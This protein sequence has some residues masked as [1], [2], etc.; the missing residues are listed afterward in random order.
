LPCAAQMEL[1]ALSWLAAGV[2]VAAFVL[3]LRG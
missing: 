3:L 2:L 1:S